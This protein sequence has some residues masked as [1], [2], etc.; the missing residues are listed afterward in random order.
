L[1]QGA[2]AFFGLFNILCTSLCHKVSSS[3]D[4][5][6]KRSVIPRLTVKLHRRKVPL[7]LLLDLGAFLLGKGLIL[8]PLV[9]SLVID[10]SFPGVYGLAGISVSSL[11]QRAEKGAKCVN[12]ATKVCPNRTGYGTLK[13]A[14][15]VH[16]PAHGVNLVLYPCSSVKIQA[17]GKLCL[18]LLQSGNAA[19]ILLAGLVSSEIAL[20][21]T[22]RSVPAFKAIY[23]FLFYKIYP[24]RI[25]N[26]PVLV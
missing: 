10:Q 26:S 23:V 2:K 13:P 25:S 20:E 12:T 24:I 7:D 21:F 5:V 8:Q 9:K 15:T 18:L 22:I 17:G 11:L 3:L 14:H 6:Y 4:R 16:F 1:P 19:L